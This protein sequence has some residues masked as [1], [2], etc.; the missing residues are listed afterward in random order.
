MFS[1]KDVQYIASLSRIHLEDEDVQHFT[2]NLADIL[3]YID[4]LN[5]VDVENIQ[6]TFHAL[7]ITNVFREDTIKPSLPQEK[8]LEI[9]VDKA[10]GSFKVPQVIE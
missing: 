5:E 7:P 2:K 1:A 8:A 6:P 10:K 4:K 9:A 3:H